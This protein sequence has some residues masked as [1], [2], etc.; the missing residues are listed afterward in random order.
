LERLIRR[1]R[2]SVS[3]RSDRMITPRSARSRVL[4]RTLLLDALE[5][6]IRRASAVLVRAAVPRP[7]SQDRVPSDSRI[8]FRVQP[9][10][11]LAVTPRLSASNDPAQLHERSR[12]SVR[13]TRWGMAATLKS[14]S[15]AV[16]VDDQRSVDGLLSPASAARS[17]L[18]MV[19]P[20]PSPSPSPSRSVSSVI[21][22][23]GSRWPDPTT[24]S[25]RSER[26]ANA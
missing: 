21:R 18:N 11:D 20:S 14:R 23:P 22:R 8:R 3:S 19:S 13:A 16:F 12:R 10:D 9:A 5:R 2:S 15:S 4:S 17:F 6:E 25:G 24:S 7:Q 1:R 26:S